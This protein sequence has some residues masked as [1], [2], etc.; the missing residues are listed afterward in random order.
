[1]TA[2]N[3]QRCGGD[4]LTAIVGCN[5]SLRRRPALRSIGIAQHSPPPTARSIENL[6]RERNIIDGSGGPV[7]FVRFYRPGSNDASKEAFT[8]GR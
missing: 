6:E 4:R 8:Y 3:Y 1:M 2:R 5:T 7:F